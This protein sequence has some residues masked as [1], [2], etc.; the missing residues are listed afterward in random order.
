MGASHYVANGSKRQF[1][2]SGAFVNDRGSYLLRGLS[3]H[4]LALLIA[5]RMPDSGGMGC[6]A[7]DP[8]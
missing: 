1:F 6:W 5:G 8:L 3:G 2:R 4:A 7:G